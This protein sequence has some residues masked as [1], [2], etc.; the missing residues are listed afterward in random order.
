MVQNAYNGKHFN[1]EQVCY[2]GEDYTIGDIFFT[3]LKNCWML[4][5]DPVDIY[6]EALIISEH[7]F[8]NSIPKKSKTMRMH[9]ITVTHKADG[10][11]QV[12]GRIDGKGSE[13]WSENCKTFYEA[14]E[15]AFE[16]AD[17]N[18]YGR[19]INHKMCKVFNRVFF[20]D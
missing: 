6:A 14:G 9:G 13:K 1:G 18:D 15:I 4:I 8:D 19:D 16:M 7:I 12:S 10:T 11:W 5:L 3:P 17:N 2:D 20:N